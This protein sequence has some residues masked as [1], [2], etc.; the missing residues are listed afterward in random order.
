MPAVAG[1]GFKGAVAWFC[2]RL[3]FAR[4]LAGLKFATLLIS[5]LNRRVD[6]IPLT[7][8]ED[9][10]RVLERELLADKIDAVVL[11]TESPDDR[12]AEIMLYHGTILGCAI[13]L[14][15]SR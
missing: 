15:R 8:V 7:L 10:T 12:L 13:Q 5:R 14:A 3:H 11:A 6:S 4:W 1:Q 2:G 9:V